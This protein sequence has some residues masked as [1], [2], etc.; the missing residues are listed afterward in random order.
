MASIAL[1]ELAIHNGASESTWRG[2]GA[3]LTRFRYK[4]SLTVSAVRSA[5]DCWAPLRLCA[6]S[7]QEAFRFTRDLTCEPS[8]QHTPGR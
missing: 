1:Q 4:K 5:V 7:K 3:L 8:P 2:A 6:L